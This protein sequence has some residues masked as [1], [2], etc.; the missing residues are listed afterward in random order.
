VE[1]QGKLESQCEQV[2]KILQEQIPMLLRHA[3]DGDEFK[4]AYSAALAVI[5][6]L[7]DVGIIGDENLLMLAR[8]AM[9]KRGKSKEVALT[10]FAYEFDHPTMPPWERVTD[11]K[12]Q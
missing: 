8:E 6:G 4:T 7:D 5:R 12:V 10:L 11:G 3:N 1:V 9:E 2:I